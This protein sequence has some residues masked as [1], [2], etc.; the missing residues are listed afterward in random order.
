MINRAVTPRIG[1]INNKITT[2]TKQ[3]NEKESMCTEPT[4]S[5][6]LPSTVKAR[7]G[8]HLPSENWAEPAEP[9]HA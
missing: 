6:Q 1:L 4:P 7:T 2:C 5:R 9:A 3:T 8:G